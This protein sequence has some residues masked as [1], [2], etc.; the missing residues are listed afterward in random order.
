MEGNLLIFVYGS[1]RRGEVNHF[2]IKDYPC[3]EDKVWIYGKL[4]DADMGYP[5]LKLSHS[6]KVEGEIYV[7]PLKDIYKLDD[8]EDYKPGEANNLYERRKVVA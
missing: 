8:F 2:I 3:L 1:L 5:F 4:Y 6:R 7:V